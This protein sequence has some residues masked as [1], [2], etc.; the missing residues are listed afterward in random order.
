MTYVYA[1]SSECFIGMPAS[2][3]NRQSDNL[4]FVLRHLSKP[5]SLEYHLLCQLIKSQVSGR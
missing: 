4:V 3:V 1:L 2:V 5:F